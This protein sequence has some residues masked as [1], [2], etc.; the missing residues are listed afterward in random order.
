MRWEYKTIKLS[1]T[2]FL[3]GGKIDEGKLDLMMNE[4]GSEG[5]ELV[6]AFGTN[7]GYGQTNSVVAI[8]K[9]QSN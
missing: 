6:T 9:R 3:V 5:W 7:K 2:G 1:A 8:F 4:L